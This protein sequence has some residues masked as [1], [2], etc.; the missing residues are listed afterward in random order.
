VAIE[1]AYHFDLFPGLQQLLLEDSTQ[2]GSYGAVFVIFL[3]NSGTGPVY[4][5]RKHIQMDLIFP[6]EVRVILKK[7]FKAVDTLTIH[8]PVILH[9]VAIERNLIRKLKS[10][11]APERF[12]R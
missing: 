4:G 12:V 11:S 8:R 7:N 2:V 6:R 10:R 3:G 1:Q 9:V 5:R